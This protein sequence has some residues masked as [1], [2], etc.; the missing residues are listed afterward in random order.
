MII[1]LLYSIIDQC[2]SLNY[3]FC[4]ATKKKKRIEWQD[5]ISQN[6]L[7]KRH[8]Y[9]KH[10]QI[11]WNTKVGDNGDNDF[12][13]T[14]FLGTKNFYLKKKWGVIPVLHL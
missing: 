3:L 8:V 5:E 10:L 14:P 6:S 7:A 12:P 9:W 2:S 4:S 13:K 1:I 11:F